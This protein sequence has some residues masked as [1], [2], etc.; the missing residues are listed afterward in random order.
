[1]M[2]RT[3]ASYLALFNYI[4]SLVPNLNPRRV[5]CDFE[6]A[7]MNAVRIVFPFPCVIVGCLWHY[8]VVRMHILLM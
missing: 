7:Q 2:R 6:R 5:H 3:Q 8:A 4:K 1:M